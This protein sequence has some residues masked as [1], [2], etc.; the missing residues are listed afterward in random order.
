MVIGITAKAKRQP[1]S[2][3]PCGNCGTPV[4]VKASKVR[5]SIMGVFFC[6]NRCSGLNRW[7][8]PPFT[9][10]QCGVV[11]RRCLAEQRK[12]PHRHNFCSSKCQ[13]EWRDQHRKDGSYKKVDGRHEHRSVAERELNRKLLN[14][15]VVHHVDEDKDNNDPRNLIVFPSQSEHFRW[16]LELRRHGR[17][18]SSDLLQFRTL[19]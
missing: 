1:A 15:E 12:S 7:K 5:R 4:K 3:F 10:D 6:S 16:H 13:L 17:I 9:C 19:A 11:F 2:V 14:R 18:I 8:L